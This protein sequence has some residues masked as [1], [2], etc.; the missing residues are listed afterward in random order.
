MRIVERTETPKSQAARQT[1]VHLTV[2]YSGQSATRA[3]L[4]EAARLS[5]GLDA[6]VRV[7]VLRPVPYPLPL[8]NPPVCVRFDRE[9]MLSFVD[10]NSDDASV[11]MSYCRDEVEALLLVLDSNLNWLP[12]S[13]VVIAGKKR[14]WLPTKEQR[15]ARRLEKAGHQ[16]VF[17]ALGG[18]Y[19]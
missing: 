3:A 11:L 15:I 5:A 4:R 6:R 2:V 16:V 17:V 10:E 1:P 12:N 19:A 8:D 9:R 18:N 7:M 14:S 13:I